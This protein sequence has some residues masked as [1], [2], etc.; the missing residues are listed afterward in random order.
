M[1]RDLRH[2]TPRAVI[3][4]FLFPDLVMN[5]FLR[6]GFA[7]FVLLMGAMGLAHAQRAV[8]PLMDF[9]DIPV[10]AAT[11]KA[12]TAEQVRQAFQVSAAAT[13]WDVT[14]LAD[15]TL[16]LSTLRNGKHAVVLAVT[17]SADKYSAV[18]VRSADMKFTESLNT[19]PPSGP[20]G[21]Q[22][23]PA[24]EDGAKKQAERFANLPESKFAVRR[25][26]AFIHPFYETWVHELLGGVRRQL[27][28][29]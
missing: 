13:K 10:S 22:A 3:P 14:P 23:V 27:A 21:W 11:A 20:M 6:R 7:T 16:Q 28:L 29:Q 15:G 18:Y 19:R 17:L 24:G 25:D 12:L 8:V 26:N 2:P 1:L 4:F 5:T 9:K